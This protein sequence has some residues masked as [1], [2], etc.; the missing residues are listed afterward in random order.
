M[1]MDVQ[2]CRRR[3]WCR[4]EMRCPTEGMPMTVISSVCWRL[5]DYALICASAVRNTISQLAQPFE[6]RAP[7]VTRTINNRS[8]AEPSEL[9]CAS[10]HVRWESCNTISERDRM[11]QSPAPPPD[12][13]TNLRLRRSNVTLGIRVWES[14][15]KSDQQ[16]ATPREL[17]KYSLLQQVPRNDGP[18]QSASKAESLE[19]RAGSL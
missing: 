9:A 14:V 1:M 18:L 16:S 19:T 2:T 3:R 4:W 8:P 17:C 13:H 6:S 10:D 15:F 12:K 7:V 5:G 11:P